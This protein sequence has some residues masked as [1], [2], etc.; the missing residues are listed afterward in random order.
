MAYWQSTRQAGFAR[1]MSCAYH[2]QLPQP[3]VPQS[4]PDSARGFVASK[5]LDGRI[6]AVEAA[7]LRA[8]K[9][10]FVIVQVRIRMGL[11]DVVRNPG[12]VPSPA[13]TASERK[14]ILAPDSNA[15]MAYRVN[16]DWR[17][18]N[19]RPVTE[20]RGQASLCRCSKACGSCVPTP[21]RG[22]ALIHLRIAVRLNPRE[23]TAVDARSPWRT[24]SIL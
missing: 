5:L 8:E 7:A 3:S 22:A 1:G 17:H 18:G 20:R 15:F 10:K 13:R 23:A 4:D 9:G 2:P 12:R 19:T 24:R 21:G 11:P 16:H 6:G 14:L